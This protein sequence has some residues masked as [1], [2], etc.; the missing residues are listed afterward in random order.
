MDNIQEFFP[1]WEDADKDVDLVL[2]TFSKTVQKQAQAKTA[3]MGQ[4]QK[5]IK[6]A[7]EKGP[8]EIQNREFSAASGLTIFYGL[9]LDAALDG[10]IFEMLQTEPNS[11]GIVYS[12]VTALCLGGDS[13]YSFLTCAF[14]TKRKL[15]SGRTYAYIDGQWTRYFTVEEDTGVT[16]CTRCPDRMNCEQYN[17]T[18]IEERRIR[19][20]VREIRKVPGIDKVMQKYGTRFYVTPDIES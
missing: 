7:I 18:L 8:E 15:P 3:L 9:P 4:M 11:A 13:P 10:G 17:E 1:A 20:A 16:D 6:S 14:I 19:Q 5:C 12:V 2:D